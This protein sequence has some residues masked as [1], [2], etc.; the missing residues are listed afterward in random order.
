MSL[1]VCLLAAHPF[2]QWKLQCMEL[3]VLRICLDT[4]D[5]THQWALP[6]KAAATHCQQ[7]AQSRTM[8]SKQWGHTCVHYPEAVK[9]TWNEEI[10]AWPDEH[11]SCKMFS[12]RWEMQDRIL[13]LRDAEFPNTHFGIPMSAGEECGKVRGQFNSHHQPLSV[14]GEFLLLL[15]FWDRVHTGLKF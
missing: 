5:Q 11:T 7:Q 3:G 15:L 12:Y 8:A 6:W 13:R 14:W 10:R 9:E 2:H 1:C 4:T